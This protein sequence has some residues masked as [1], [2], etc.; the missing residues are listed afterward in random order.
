MP[1]RVGWDEVGSSLAGLLRHACAPAGVASQRLVGRV[2]RATAS[3]VTCCMPARQGAQTHTMCRLRKL[4]VVFGTHAAPTFPPRAPARLR[5]AS[6]LCSPFYP[7][8]LPG[9]YL[10][11][12][13]V[14]GR[15]ACPCRVVYAPPTLFCTTMC[16]WVWWVSLC[17]YGWLCELL[18]QCVCCSSCLSP[19]RA[20]QRLRG[21][22]LVGS[23]SSLFL[24]LTPRVPHVASCA[25]WPLLRCASGWVGPVPLCYLSPRRCSMLCLGVTRA[26]V[27][28]WWALSWWK[29]FV[30]TTAKQSALISPACPGP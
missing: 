30:C 11:R 15:S 9:L 16:A 29:A 4:L 14:S 7:T 13:C 12:R 1:R 3:S 21:R 20:W 22:G 10:F 28:V 5:L 6:L 2:V 26:A 19:D 18:L 17:G 27:F 24:R 23:P 8:T 25:Q